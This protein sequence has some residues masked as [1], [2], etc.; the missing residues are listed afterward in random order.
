LRKSIQEAKD[1]IKAVSEQLVTK[2]TDDI[3]KDIKSKFIAEYVNKQISDRR[4]TEKVSSDSLALLKNLDTFTSVD[5]KLD[6]ITSLLKSNALH[7]DVI[8]EVVVKSSKTDNRQ[9]PESSKKMLTDLCKQM[10]G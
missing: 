6:E 4:L 9:L 2:L 5:D 1:N 8:T 10:F 3:T 7:N